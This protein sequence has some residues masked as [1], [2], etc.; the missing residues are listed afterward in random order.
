[1]SRPGSTAFIF[2]VGQLRGSGVPDIG[3][4][5]MSEQISRGKMRI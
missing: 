4:V 2:P 3:L 5:T 1:L